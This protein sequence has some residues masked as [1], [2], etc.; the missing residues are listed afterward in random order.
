MKEATFLPVSDG[1]EV[2]VLLAVKE[3]LLLQEIVKEVLRSYR[4]LLA[5]ELFLF[6][7]VG[8]GE[9]RFSD[10]T[11][12]LIGMNWWLLFGV[13]EEDDMLMEQE[14]TTMVSESVEK[15]LLATIV[16]VQCITVYSYCTVQNMWLKNLEI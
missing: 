2:V 3:G 4:V 11:V 5:A 1:V 6:V 10:R 8:N 16:R 15:R 12:G 14:G 7:P 13:V 9:E